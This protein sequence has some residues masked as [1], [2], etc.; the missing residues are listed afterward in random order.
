LLNDTAFVLERNDLAGWNAAVR[1]AAYIGNQANGSLT[2]LSAFYSDDMPETERSKYNL[3]VIG[4]PSQMPL[5]AQ[6]NN[7]LPAPFSVGSDVASAN[8]LQ[9]I[10]RIPA[11][12][13]MG[14]I[15]EMPSPW[16]PSKVVLATLGNTT[17]GVQWA[18]SALIDPKLNGLLAG[19]FAVV[20][21]HQIITTDTHLASVALGSNAATQA[22]NAIA[23]TPPS[24][25][26][27]LIAIARPN[28]I[29]PVLALSVFLIILVLAI[30]AISSWSRNRTGRS[31]RGI[32]NNDNKDSLDLPK[33]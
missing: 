21:D 14:Y 19:N 8:N 13:P 25:N 2:G 32:E 17:Q 15:E 3:L 5:V 10:Y 9:V 29:L 22:P 26:S 18:T 20:N 7:S 16:N 12:S 30:V 6:M 28:W 23:T 1:I 27:E 24:A 33:K 11:N 4:Q 31:H